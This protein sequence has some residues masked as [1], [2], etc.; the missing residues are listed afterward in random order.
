MTGDAGGAENGITYT[1]AAVPVDWT[2]ADASFTPTRPAHNQVVM[3]FGAGAIGTNVDV[4]DLYMIQNRSTPTL[5]WRRV[6]S[7]AAATT[8]TP[9]LSYTNVGNARYSPARGRLRLRV[10]NFQGTSGAFFL[11][12]GAAGSAGALTLSY[13]AG[14]LILRIWDDVA[15]LVCTLSCGAVNTAEHTYTVE[16]DAAIG[17]AA[18]FEGATVLGSFGGTWV[19]EPNAVAPIYVGCDSVGGSAARCLIALLNGYDF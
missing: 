13:N 11:T 8:S 2:R 9:T 1:D 7:P 4:G 19:P 12:C 5:A 18:V 15:A 16:W 14:A 10:A 17:K 6:G 3:L